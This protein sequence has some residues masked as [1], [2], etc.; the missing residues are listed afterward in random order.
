MVNVSVSVDETSRIQCQTVD[1]H[2]RDVLAASV[3]SPVAGLVLQGSGPDP[4]IINHAR[5]ARQYHSEQ[6]TIQKTNELQKYTPYVPK[7]RKGTGS[8]HTIGKYSCLE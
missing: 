3:K 2:T 5:K 1:A 4:G 8:I 7:A 6:N